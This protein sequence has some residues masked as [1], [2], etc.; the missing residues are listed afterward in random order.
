MWF[1]NYQSL[2]YLFISRETSTVNITKLKNDDWIQKN[3]IMIIGFALAAGLGSVVQLIIGSALVIILS[4]AIPFC[5]AMLAYL[6]STK[7][8]I[9]TRLLPYI[10]LIL[11]FSIAVSVIIFSEANLGSIGIIILLLVLGSI[12]GQMRI[13]A[14]GFVLSLIA[15]VMNNVLFTAPALV[16]DSGTNLII[17]HVLAGV[18]LFLLVR[19]NGRVFNH[20]EEL[21]EATARKAVEEEAL[22]SKLDSAVIKITSNLEQLRTNTNTVG[23]SQREMLEAVNEV[24][25]G[26]QHQA[27]HI[28]DIAE[29]TEQTHSAVQDISEGLGLVVIQA[30]EAGI[31]ADEGATKVAQLKES[32]DTFSTFFNELF[33]TFTLLS[34]KIDETNVFAE[35]IKE[36][37]AQTNLLALNASIEAARAGE[38]GQGFAVVANEIRKL[39][40]LTDGTLKKIDANLFDVN[41]YNKLAVGKLTEGLT[42]IATQIEV[43]DDSSESF[44]DLFQT[45]S[46]LQ[47]DL[48]LFIVDFGTVGTNSETVRER[49]VEF[50]AIIQQ[51]TAAI[52]ELNATLTEL[53][54]EQ[55]QI[56]R[57]I[58]ET[59]DEAV[60]LRN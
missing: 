33:E 32:I 21:V 15:L 37:T 23:V 39:S 42:Q 48:S 4:V 14:F 30:N 27:D 29:N 47:E 56:A 60:Q 52:E 2:D 41:S 31:K 18:V 53:T 25:A 44:T 11:N 34:E 54:D 26:S 28:S 45:M 24:S 55:D 8:S 51:S 35:S 10:L 17:L 38:H 46:K 36:I 16:E 3:R 9:V 13:L 59:H 50:A 6:V 22:A 5:L 7:V 20:V 12:H 49:T 58:N 57:Y 19:Q 40:G 43:A 1:R